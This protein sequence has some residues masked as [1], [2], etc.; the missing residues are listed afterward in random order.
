MSDRANEI[1]QAIIEQTEKPASPQLIEKRQELKRAK[2]LLV[3]FDSPEIKALVSRLEEE[4]AVLETGGFES[5]RIKQQ[6]EEL[7]LTFQDP[8]IFNEYSN[9][10][11]YEIYHQLVNEVRIWNKEVVSVSLLI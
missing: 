4:I 2:G 6:R 5:D 9:A 3:Q 10:E 1:V 11:R 7:L 8:D